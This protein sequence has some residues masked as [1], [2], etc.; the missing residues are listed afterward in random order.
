MSSKPPAEIQTLIEGHIKG[1]NTQDNDLFLSV[2]G[3][4]AIIIDDDS[5]SGTYFVGFLGRPVGAVIFGRH[6]IAWPQ[7]DAHC[8]T[9]VRGRSDLPS[10]VSGPHG[11]RRIPLS[12]TF[13][14][15][16]V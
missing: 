9:P 11:R 7:S 12:L 1:F 3:D 4:T 15:T 16:K 14:G 6:A 10:W 8:H 13:D 2:F 5:R